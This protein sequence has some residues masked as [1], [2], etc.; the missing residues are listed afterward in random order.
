MNFVCFCVYLYGVTFLVVLPILCKDVIYSVFYLYTLDQKDKR[1]DSMVHANDH[2]IKQARNFFK[3]RHVD[4]MEHLVHTMTKQ[5]DVLFTVLTTSRNR[6]RPNRYQPQYLTQTLARL[7]ELLDLKQHKLSSQVAICN[8]DHDPSSYHEFWWVRNMTRNVHTFQKQTGR[9]LSVLHPVEK[10]KQD[11]VFCLESSGTF[12]AKYV[13]LL[14]DD[15]LPH[16]DFLTVLDHVLD[17]HLRV[18]KHKDELYA[19]SAPWSFVKLY[20]PERL[21]G[22]FSLE[23]ERLLELFSIGAFCGTILS[24]IYSQFWTRTRKLYTWLMFALYAMILVMAVGRTNVQELRRYFAPYLYSIVP[25][26]DCCTPAMLYPREQISNLIQYMDSME[27]TLGFAKDSVL[28]QYRT[29]KQLSA[30]LVQPNL[31]QHIGLHSALRN[32]VTDPFVL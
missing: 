27:C 10:E 19:Q 22:Y 1:L 12:N 5:V 28:T 14:E 4:E 31:I 24:L 25:A 32:I 13:L 3:K 23:Q 6:N 7:L 21:Q 2:R 8:V 11:Y 9:S 18:I 20:H 26:P 15:A 29:E 16:S 17:F 30:Y